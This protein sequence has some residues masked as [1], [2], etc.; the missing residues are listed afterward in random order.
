MQVRR[1]VRRLLVSS[2]GEER[3][4]KAGEIERRLRGRAAAALAPYD[5]EAVPR[6]A[7][8]ADPAPGPRGGSQAYD[9]PE[10]FLDFPRPVASR[11]EL[12]SHLHRELRPRTYFEVGVA[13]GASM[14][15][16]RT[17]SLGVDPAYQVSAQLQCDVQLVRQESDSFFAGE[18]PF[19]HFAGTPV[20]LAFI[21]GLHLSE[22]ALRDFMNTEKVMSRTG[23]VVIDDVMPRNRLESARDRRTLA[24]TGD[25]YKVMLILQEQ[26]PD[27]TIIPVNTRPTGTVIVMGLD[28]G[29]RVLE[30]NYQANLERCQVPDPQEPPEWVMRRQPPVRAADDVLRLPWTSL[31]EL[32][33][34]DPTADVVRAAVA[35][36][37]G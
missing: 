28:P 18:E 5:G 10:P 4:A 24:W 17:R 8:R 3:T 22:F 30:D 34:D 19:A 36:L 12:L 7:K 23:V 33:G 20:D 32:R 35:G 27:L 31:R 15:L 13:H 29:S 2:L 9:P 16:S 11:H 37:A 21:D 26:R 6:Q 1:S 25:V 14:A